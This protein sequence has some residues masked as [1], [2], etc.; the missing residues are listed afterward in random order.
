MIPKG[1]IVLSAEEKKKQRMMYSI[2]AIAEKT[3]AEKK[4][5]KCTENDKTDISNNNNN[6]DNKDNSK[7]NNKD[8]NNKDKDRTIQKVRS[9]EFKK[10]DVWDGNITSSMI[11][12]TPEKKP[13]RELQPY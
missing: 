13:P 12:E 8:N 4:V 2:K 10:S 7:D 9:R 11:I 1:V 3:S 6:K 5:E